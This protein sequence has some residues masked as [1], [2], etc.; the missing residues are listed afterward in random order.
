MES[1]PAMAP[2]LHKDINNVDI[3]PTD[4]DHNSNDPKAK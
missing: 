3:K 1:T 2:Q 4:H